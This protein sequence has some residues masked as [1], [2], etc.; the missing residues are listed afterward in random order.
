M[1][2]RQ[3]DGTTYSAPDE[4]GDGPTRNLGILMEG[5]TDVEATAITRQ[6][7]EVAGITSMNPE[8]GA[9][10]LAF[11]DATGTL[12]AAASK[13]AMAS[14]SPYARSLG[15]FNRTVAVRYQA[16]LAK[17]GGDPAEVHGQFVAAM[18]SGDLAPLEAW[19]DERHG[20][21]CFVR[22]F[23]AP[24]FDTESELVR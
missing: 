15:R 9:S 20:P 11:A 22:M 3:L 16:L 1:N 6:T 17:L 2:F 5:A 18:I 7:A 23:R 4:P 19:L 24:C 12:T 14:G 21:G 8:P 13:A 10:G